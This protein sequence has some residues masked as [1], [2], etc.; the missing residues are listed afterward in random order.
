MHRLIGH[1]QTV[2]MKPEKHSC[3][4]SSEF[5]KYGSFNWERK[6]K[7]FSQVTVI[8]KFSL[9][10][11]ARVYVQALVGQHLENLGKFNEKILG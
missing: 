4:E 2:Q 8:I 10:G 7:I 5:S 9:S 11:N 6:I 1:G 3:F